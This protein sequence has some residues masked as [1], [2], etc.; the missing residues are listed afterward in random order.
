MEELRKTNKKMRVEMAEL[1]KTNG[2]MENELKSLN[3]ALTKE[4]KTNGKLRDLVG[5]SPIL[6]LIAE[7]KETK[8]ERDEL[9]AEKLYNTE[10]IRR[11]VDNIDKLRTQNAELRQENKSL[12][13][14]ESG[15]KRKRSN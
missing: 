3:R 10:T 9:K 2:Q 12:S 8:Q 4:L 11:H 13:G 14:Q 1:R 6:K 7:L 5:K 15:S